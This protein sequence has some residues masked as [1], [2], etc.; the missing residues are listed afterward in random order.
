MEIGYQGLKMALFQKLFDI[1]NIKREKME[2]GIEKIRQ[3][4]YHLYVFFGA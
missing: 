2:E 3:K 1:M 4:M